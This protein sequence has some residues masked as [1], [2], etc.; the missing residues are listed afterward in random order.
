MRKSI[1]AGLAVLALGAGAWFFMTP[2]TQVSAADVIVYKSPWCGCC[3]KWV[4][5]MRQ[6][7]FTVAVHEREDMDPIKRKFKVPENLESCHTAIVGGYTIEGH[8]P[9]ADIRRLLSERPKARG[10]TVPGMPTGSPGMEMDNQH[11]PYDVVLFDD[12]GKGEVYARH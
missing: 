3:S 2:A 6:N 8:V 12:S 5:H 4:T 11:D 1:I 9:A 10:L 7:G